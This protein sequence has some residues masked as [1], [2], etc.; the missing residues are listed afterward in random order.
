MDTFD[1]IAA[2]RS[3]KKF[4]PEHELAADELTRLMKAAALTPTSFNIQNYRFVVVTDPSVKQQ[5][6]EAGWNQAQFTDCSALV[7]VCGDQGAYAKDPARY[8]ANAAPAVRDA[9]VP[10]ILGYYGTHEVARRDENLRSGGMAAMTLM[11]AAKAM[12]YDTCPM[13]GF[14]FTKVAAIINL[15]RDHDIVMAVAVGK[16]IEPARERSGQVPLDELVIRDR[17]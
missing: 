15:P 13:V 17:F 16:A 9:V 8:W 5:I 14:D 11:L 3:V 1:A 4:D 12:G 6:R 10:M 2:R 7:I